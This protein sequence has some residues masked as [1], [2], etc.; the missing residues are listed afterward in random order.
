LLAQLLY[1]RSTAICQVC[2][3]Y[4]VTISWRKNTGRLTKPSIYDTIAAV[5]NRIAL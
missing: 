1:Q 5:F 4:L 3:H 2:L